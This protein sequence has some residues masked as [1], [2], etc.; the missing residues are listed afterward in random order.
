MIA[1]PYGKE[2]VFSPITS[3]AYMN[4]RLMVT[5]IKMAG[6]RP[7][8]ERVM[9]NMTEIYNFASGGFAVDF[10]G[11]KRDGSDNLNIAA[12]G[13]RARLRY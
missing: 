7:T 6:S 10:S 9:Q 4:I 1:S 5:A 8:V 12:D 3:D 13:Q 2:I 11:S